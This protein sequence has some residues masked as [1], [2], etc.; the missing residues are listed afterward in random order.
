MNILLGSD[1]NYAPYL[2]M[3]IFNI[4]KYDKNINFYILDM[5]IS[6]EN[7]ENI[8][9]IIRNKGRCT[10][11]SIREEDF[12][13]FPVYHIPLIAYAR[14]KAA[15]YIPEDKVLYLDTDLVISGSLG[16]LYNQDLEGKSIGV[17]YDSFVNEDIEHLDKIKVR[18]DSYFN[19]GVMLLN[20][21]KWR[22]KNI[23]SLAINWIEKNHHIAKYQD[24]DILNVIFDNDVKFLDPKFNFMPHLNGKCKRKGIQLNEKEKVTFPVLIYHYCGF[25]KPWHD[26]VK[27]PSGYLS[28]KII[29]ELTRFFWKDRFKEDSFVNI[30][31]KLIGKYKYKFKY[32]IY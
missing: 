23:F 14:L 13:K 22:E 32:K 31:K 20:L 26:D 9:T 12:N 7:K 17:I 3:V 18:K 21:S 27:F 29:T 2:G 19:S 5:N 25:V 15:E 1:D 10:F 28:Y 6:E 8:R 30:I 24:Q 11:I 4:L 16:E